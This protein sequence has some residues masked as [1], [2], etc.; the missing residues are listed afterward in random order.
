MKS[1]KFFV[2]GR[3]RTPLPNCAKCA[4]SS[5]R[6]ELHRPETCTC[7]T[8]HGF[9]AASEAPVILE[10]MAELY[11]VNQWAVRTG[12]ASGIVV[13]DV[14]GPTKDP[15][16]YETL[17]NWAS[18]TGWHLPDVT[19]QARSPSGGLHLY[20]AFPDVPKIPS[21]NRILPGVDLKAD[22]GYVV[23][24]HVN[25]PGR[26]WERRGLPTPPSVEM[27]E[28][29]TTAHGSG[30]T[31]TSVGHVA[32]YDFARFAREGAPEGA[33]EEFFNDLLFRLR[34]RGVGR[35]EAQAV[36]YEHWQRCEQRTWFWDWRHVL[37]KLDRIW[38][39]VEP[40]EAPEWQVLAAQRLVEKTRAELDGN[41]SSGRRTMAAP[42]RWSD[43]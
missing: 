43:T 40:N 35:R 30:G 16:G 39:T 9:Y 42:T 11:P 6:Y 24:P 21:R 29:L 15:A 12:A 13:L 38:R 20:F 1:W 4:S 7:L 2:L 5:D 25:S 37:Y 36:A 27:V 33:R 34:K 8:C 32:G 23:V 17:E 3:D 14:E 10:L 41:T 19:L 31:G 28:W 22:G 26:V 18:Y